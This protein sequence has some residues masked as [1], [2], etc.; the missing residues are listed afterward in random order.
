MH[1]IRWG[2]FYKYQLAYPWDRYRKDSLKHDI[3]WPMREIPL[4]L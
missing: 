2:G 3:S 1:D 4:D